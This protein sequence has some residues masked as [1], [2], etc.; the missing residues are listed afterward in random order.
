MIYSLQGKISETGK[1]FFVIE[2][3]G[4]SFQ[5]FVSGFLLE[6]I[7]VNQTIKILTHLEL[8]ENTLELYGF[9]NKKESEYFKYLVAISGIGPKSAMN[10]LSLIRLPDLEKAVLNEKP[11]ILTKVSGIGKKTAQRIVLE[12]KGKIV[13]KPETFP[14]QEEDDSLVIDALVS[15]GYTLA[16]AR[17]A[18]KKIPLEIK[19]TNKRLKQTLKILS[20]R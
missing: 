13:K 7:N 19:G 11:D 9:E 14:G 20:G 4:V 18:I 6:K 16:Q 12:F 2:T 8:K 1:D 17:E 15:M 3:G 10:V 5:V